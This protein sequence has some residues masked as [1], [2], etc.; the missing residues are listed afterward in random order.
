VYSSREVKRC[1][2]RLLKKVAMLKYARYYSSLVKRG[3][4]TQVPNSGTKSPGKATPPK[5]DLD[6]LNE[7]AS[8]F[9]TREYKP[10]DY[11]ST[12]Y[13]LSQAKNPEQLRPYIRSLRNEARTLKE[14]IRNETK[15]ME[16]YMKRMKEIEKQLMKSFRKKEPDYTIKDI[17]ID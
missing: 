7:F 6:E 8:V 2:I 13:M 14:Q 9:K 4:D 17:P 15:M 10:F 16:I 1:A 11:H 3:V 5:S 12:Y